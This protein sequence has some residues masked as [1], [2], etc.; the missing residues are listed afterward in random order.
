ME[1]SLLKLLILS[2]QLH[3][4]ILNYNNIEIQEEVISKVN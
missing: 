4:K 3:V 1:L 2:D